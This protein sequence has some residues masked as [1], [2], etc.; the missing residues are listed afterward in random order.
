MN[1][2]KLTKVWTD[3]MD[4]TI[5]KYVGGKHAPCKLTDESEILAICLGMNLAK[6]KATNKGL[7]LTTVCRVDIQWNGKKFDVYHTKEN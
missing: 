6:F 4:A 7:R 2:D 3:K 5:K 1:I